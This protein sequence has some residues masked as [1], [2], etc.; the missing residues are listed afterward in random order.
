[1]P[2]CCAFEAIEPRLMLTAPVFV[3]AVADA[4]SL[5]VVIDYTDVN[6]STIGPGDITIATGS[7]G[8]LAATSVLSTQVRPLGVLR[9]TYAVPAYDGAWGASDT[10]TYMIVSPPGQVLDQ[11]GHNLTFSNVASIWLWFG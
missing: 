8:A 7:R 4:T 9:V 11:L 5:A 6:Q 3:G 2:S 1:M 10:G